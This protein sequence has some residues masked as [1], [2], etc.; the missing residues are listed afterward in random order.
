MWWCTLTVTLFYFIQYTYHILLSTTFHY[1][2]LCTRLPVNIV[3]NSLQHSRRVIF[4]YLSS[5]SSCKIK[6]NTPLSLHLAVPWPST[7]E[8]NFLRKIHYLCIILYYIIY[9]IIRLYRCTAHVYITLINRDIPSK[10]YH[11]NGFRAYC[12]IIFKI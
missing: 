11:K 8:I 9:Y 1:T 4:N 12:T 6:F 2:I 5:A 10:R 7:C 3:H